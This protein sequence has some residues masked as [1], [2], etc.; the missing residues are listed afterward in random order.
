MAKTPDMKTL[1]RNTTQQP[2]PEQVATL[3]E[4][5]SIMSGE[6]APKLPH[7]IDE[8]CSSQGSGPREVIEQARKDAEAGLEDDD[9]GPPMDATYHREFRSQGD[10]SGASDAQPPEKGGP[11]SGPRVHRGSDK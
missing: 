11:I 4:T 10:A 5:T 9:L 1:V 7:E 6:R 2:A 8:S 3:G